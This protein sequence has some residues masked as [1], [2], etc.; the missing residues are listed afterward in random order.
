[1]EGLESPAEDFGLDGINSMEPWRDDE[2]LNEG[3][4]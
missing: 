2:R 1:M 3:S 4:W